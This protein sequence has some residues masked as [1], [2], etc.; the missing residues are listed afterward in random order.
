M[1]GRGWAGLRGAQRTK[2]KTRKVDARL[3]DRSGLLSYSVQVERAV[4]FLPWTGCKR[5][6]AKEGEPPPVRCPPGRA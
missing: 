3:M 4:T 6:G 5:S 1:R 2:Q